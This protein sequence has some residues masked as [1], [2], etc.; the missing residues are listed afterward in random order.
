ME[1]KDRIIQ[2]YAS[3][4]TDLTHQ[5]VLLIDQNQTLQEENARLKED[6]DKLLAPKKDSKEQG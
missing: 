3:R 4:G 5:I 1:N 6:I 2:I